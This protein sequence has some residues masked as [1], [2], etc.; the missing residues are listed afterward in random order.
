MNY[1]SGDQLDDPSAAEIPFTR[2][3][4][5]WL[6]RELE[7][8][9]Q[10][11]WQGRPIVRFFSL[12]N[13]L[14]YLLVT[15]WLIGAIVLMAGALLG[16]FG[17]NGNDATTGKLVLFLVVLPFVVM[18]A[19][20]LW[21]P[22]IGYLEKCNRGYVITDRRAIFIQIVRKSTVRSYTPDMLRETFRRERKNGSGD[23]IFTTRGYKDS[24][25]EAWTEETGFFNVPHA[26]AV[27]AL[28]KGLA[29]SKVDTVGKQS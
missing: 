24:E 11:I 20:L 5:D 4:Q 1:E 12:G 23:V 26:R 7:P 28:V 13:L 17:F 22:Y 25:G 10:V 18:A 29:N 19:A 8:G 9:E 6:D 27:E 2:E 3:L 21:G 16:W 15:P 14:I